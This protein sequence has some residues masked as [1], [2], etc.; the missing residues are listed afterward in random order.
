MCDIRGIGIDMC[1]IS[2]MENEKNSSLLLRKCFTEEEAAY[3]TSKGVSMAQSMAGLWAAKE[4]VLKALGKGITVPM[5]DVEIW[6]DDLGAPKVRLSGRARELV[7]QGEC[8][9]SIAHEGD[10]AAAFCVLTAPQ[11]AAGADSR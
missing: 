11:P 2:R 8:L 3:L 10:Y 4:A 1:L 7:P 6:H 9:V 5:R